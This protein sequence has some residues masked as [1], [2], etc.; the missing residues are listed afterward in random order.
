MSSDPP[1]EYPGAS[2]HQVYLE[3]LEAKAKRLDAVIQLAKGVQKT[4]LS[5]LKK[6]DSDPRLA[7]IDIHER[8]RL[9]AEQESELRIAQKIL[10]IANGGE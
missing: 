9:K 4:S 7:A 6:C 1:I 2:E 10:K 5:W 8:C 3:E